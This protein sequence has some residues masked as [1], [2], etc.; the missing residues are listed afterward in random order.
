MIAE[1]D[2]MCGELV[3]ID[4]RHT[5]KLEILG[6]HA[7][8]LTSRRDRWGWVIWERLDAR[9]WLTYLIACSDPG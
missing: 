4:R 5:A 9:S 7:F 2:D 3:R 8:E 6:T 1:D